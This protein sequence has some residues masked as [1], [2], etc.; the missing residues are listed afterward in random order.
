MTTH[1]KQLHVNL[2]EMACVSHIVH[3]M[4]RAPGNNRHRF[5]DMSYWLEVAKLAEEGLFDAIFLADV[6]GTYDALA[7][8][9]QQPCV[10]GYRFPILILSCWCPPWL[11]LRKTLDLA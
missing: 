9:Q 1:L 8:V 11:Q 2:F 10:K 5:G 4:W 3:G 7:M 6:I